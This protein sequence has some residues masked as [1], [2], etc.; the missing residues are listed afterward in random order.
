MKPLCEKEMI[1]D[2]EMGLLLN[3][4]KQPY[5]KEKIEPANYVK[6]LPF[7]PITVDETVYN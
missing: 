4:V 5:N 6:I 2:F 7:D 3:M 1:S